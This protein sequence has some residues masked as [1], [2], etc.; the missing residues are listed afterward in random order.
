[1][2]NIDPADPTVRGVLHGLTLDLRDIALTGDR[3]SALLEPAVEL[4]EASHAIHRAF[5]LLSEW[6]DPTTSDRL[7]EA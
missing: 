6:C 7:I 2:T 3:A 5:I 1:M 4:L